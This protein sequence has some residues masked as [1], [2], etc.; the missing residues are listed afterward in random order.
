[1]YVRR[2]ANIPK[3]NSISE[4]KVITLGGI[5]QWMTIRGENKRLPVLLFLH[6]GPGTSQMAFISDY[7]KELEAH[8]VVVNWDQRGSGLSY[9]KEVTKESMTINQLLADTIELTNYLREKFQ[10]DKIYVI[11]YSW[12]SILGLLAIHDRPEL[13]HHYIGVSQVIGMGRVEKIS[14][15]LLLEKAKK[16]KHQKAVNELTNIGKPPWRNIKYDR[17]YRRYLEIFK[18]GISFDGKLMGN[19]VKKFLASSEY[20]LLDT[21]RFLKGQ[22]F[23]TTCLK[24]EMRRLDLSEKI[25]HVDVPFTLL[26]GRYD[27]I[28]PPY[29]TKDWFDSVQAKVKK[30]V[31]FE[32]SAHSPLFEENQKFIE[33]VLTETQC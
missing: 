31:W 3:E 28:T 5:Q 7:Q 27:L 30:W 23:S 4:L 33:L 19:L 22:R 14:Y 29:V 17:T 8:F 11:G 12:G 32:H 21:I 16:H 9:T 25:L 26:M 1:M 15:H 20:T 18:R 13:Y 6:G 24:D 10:Q 2:T